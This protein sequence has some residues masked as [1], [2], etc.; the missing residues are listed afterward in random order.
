MTL[1]LDRILTFIFPS[2]HILSNLHHGLLTVNILE[3]MDDTNS[4]NGEYTDV[5]A[6]HSFTPQSH[7]YLASAPT[8]GQ[9]VSVY[10][11]RELHHNKLL[12]NTPQDTGSLIK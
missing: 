6:M 8:L 10:D 3:H 7:Q 4:V 12:L 2:K 9:K 11:T 5:D 1:L